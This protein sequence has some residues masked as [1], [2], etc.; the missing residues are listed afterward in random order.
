MTQTFLEPVNV[1]PMDQYNQELVANVHPP[2]WVNP[3]PALKLYNISNARKRKG[4]SSGSV[5]SSSIA[6]CWTLP[7]PS[8]LN[9][10]VSF[11]LSNW[12]IA[13]IAVRTQALQVNPQIA[14]AYLG[15]GIAR[16]Y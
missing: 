11:V 9:Q 13:T 6:I 3:E 10:S 14:D 5:T 1:V 8:I 12:W 16:H 4:S 7:L 15:R 2:N